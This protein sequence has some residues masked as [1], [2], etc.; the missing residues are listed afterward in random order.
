MAI[1]KAS[2][3]IIY[4]MKNNAGKDLIER[5]ESRQGL[6]QLS[7]MKEMKMGNDNYKIVEI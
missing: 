4:N 1:D 7:Y 5:I 2:V 3:D 6:R